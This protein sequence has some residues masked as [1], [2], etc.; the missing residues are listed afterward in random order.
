MNSVS[1]LSSA[2][3]PSAQRKSSAGPQFLH[4][5]AVVLGPYLLAAILLLVGGAA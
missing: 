3:R 5:L 1:Q 4:A 2:T